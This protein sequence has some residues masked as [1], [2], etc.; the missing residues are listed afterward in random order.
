[1]MNDKGAT[2]RVLRKDRSQPPQSS[3]GNPK[4]FRRHIEFQND[5]FPKGRN[6]TK[7]NNKNEV[8]LQF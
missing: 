8:F 2:L 7:K 1:M 4:D 5:L 6:K 3:I